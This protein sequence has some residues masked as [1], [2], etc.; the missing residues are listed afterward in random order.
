M[1][2]ADQQRLQQLEEAFVLFTETSERL[3]ESY[4]ALQA[5]T[6]QLQAQLAQSD[7]EKARVAERLT[8]LLALLPAAV[9]VLNRDNQVT[10]LNPSA[11]V[12]LGEV[13]NQPWLDV[14]ARTFEKR[15]RG[16]ELITPQGRIFQLTNTALDAELGR[17]LL[18]QEVT[19]ARRLQQQISRQQRLSSMGEMAASLAHQIRTPLASAL[20][21]ASQLDEAELTPVQQQKFSAKILTSLQ[22]L[23]ALVQDMLQY[24]KGG[25]SSQ[26]PLKV[27]DLMTQ[28]LA[29]MQA[30]I[31][32]SSAE[33]H[34]DQSAGNLQV[35][36]D[37]DALSTAL[38]NLINNALE[39]SRGPQAVIRLSV[40]ANGDFIDLIVSD[41]GPGI[42]TEKLEK[43]FEPFY[44]SRAKG[45]GLGLAVVRAVAEA[46][47]GEAW[48][49][50]IL[51][52][53]SQFGL[54]LPRHG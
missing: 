42:E 17:I 45:T 23:E 47:Q 48:V 40:Q 34:Y 16:G 10:E 21:Y 7:M 51:G 18:L 5:R 2:T 36:G 52:F 1:H 31:E 43:I 20:L 54:R 33:V 35:L 19:E 25:K 22:H 53:G 46:H 12:L 29:H 32:Q 15:Q 24:A 49:K 30:R 26:T 28:T 8:R 3:T 27:S 39:H 41:N 44:T 4:H 6:A 13:L 37:M 14:Q 38:Q 11:Q 9:V 50:S